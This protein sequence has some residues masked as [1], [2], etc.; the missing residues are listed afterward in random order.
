MLSESD[1]EREHHGDEWEHKYHRLRSAYSP[2]KPLPRDRSQKT[3]QSEW[4]VFIAAVVIGL[5]IAVFVFV[6]AGSAIP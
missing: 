6:G 1:E 2:G 5:L 3:S 4:A